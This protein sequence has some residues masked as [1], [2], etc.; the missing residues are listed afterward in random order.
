MSL[1]RQILSVPTRFENWG[2]FQRGFHSDTC[3]GQAP[4]IFRVRDVPGVPRTQKGWV[5][6][7]LH[8]HNNKNYN[9]DRRDSL[10]P[11]SICFLF[12]SV[13]SSVS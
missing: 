9:V 10:E 8:I 13:W 11:C 1:S 12:F 2:S 6:L 3:Y 4:V 5:L 7:A